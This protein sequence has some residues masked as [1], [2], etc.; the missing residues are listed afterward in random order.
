MSSTSGLKPGPSSPTEMRSVASRS[1]TS[2]QMVSAAKSTAFWIRLRTP[3][4]ISGRRTTIGCASP[5][6][7]GGW[8]LMR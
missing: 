8:P 1:R 6:A 2:I 5:T 4:M 7:S 3:W